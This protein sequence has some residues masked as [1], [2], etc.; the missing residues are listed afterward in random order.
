MV[1]GPGEWITRPTSAAML[2]EIGHGTD[3][4]AQIEGLKGMNDYAQTVMKMQLNTR[5]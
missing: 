2:M 3:K 1:R 5:V 4:P